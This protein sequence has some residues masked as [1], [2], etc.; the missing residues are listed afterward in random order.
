MWFEHLTS[1]VLNRWLSPAAPARPTGLLL[2][3][4]VEPP[5]QTVVL[6]DRQ[7]CQHAVI[8][9]KTGSGKTYCLNHWPGSWPER[10]EGFAF[11]DFH[12][13]SSLSLISRLSRTPRRGRATRHPGSIPSHAQPRHQRAG[14]R[15]G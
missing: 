12:G 1:S 7:R 13:D 5:H 15:R 8:L 4:T 9:G 6:P 2:G 10:G 11:L 14:G 3:K